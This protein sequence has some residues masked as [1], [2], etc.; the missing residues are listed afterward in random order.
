V[1]SLRAERWIRTNARQIFGAPSIFSMWSAGRSADASAWNASSSLFAVAPGR[2]VTVRITADSSLVS[3][4][5]AYAGLLTIST[6]SPYASAGP[7]KMTMAVPPPASW[8]KITGTVTGSGGAPL[9]GAT[10]AICTM[11]D[12]KTGACGPA[13]FTL[14]TDGAG[15]Y[16]LWLNRGFNPLQVIAAKDGYTPAMKIARIQKGETVTTDFAL[17]GDSAFTKAKVQEYL[18]NTMHGE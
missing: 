13:K 1:T 8:G 17:T 9:A 7:V 3:Q 2:T 10:V 15:H 6:D 18:K 16:Q 5:G 14:K 4:P 12:T 11:D